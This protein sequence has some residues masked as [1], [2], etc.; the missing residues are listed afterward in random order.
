MFFKS[1]SGRFLL[2][3]IIFVML[4]EVLIFV[5]SVARFRF[6]YLTERLER[7]QIASLSLLAS[8]DEMISTE[9]E[10]EL[11]YNADVLN[12][13]LRRNSVRQ[14]V[15]S[16]PMPS[17]VDESF[18]LRNDSG[19]ELIRDAFE[20]LFIGGNRI[21]RVIGEP[22]KRG[23]ELIEITL[24]ETPMRRAM[25]EYGRNILVLSFVISLF[26]AMLL[27]G[28]VRRF[29]VR[30]IERLVRHIRY[31]QDA[32]EDARAIIQPTANVSELYDAETA[33]HGMETQL[34]QSLRQKE[35]L[36][37]LGG[38]VSKISHDL[39][40]IL[41]TTQLL[42]DRME[43]SNDPAVQRNAPKLVD[44]LSRAVNLCESTLTFGKAEEQAPE[45]SYFPLGLLLEDVVESELL[46]VEGGNIEITMDAPEGMRIE[47]DEEQI[48]RVVSNLVRNGR[49]VLSSREETGKIHVSGS[50]EDDAYTIT[51]RDNGP[52]VPE[53]A[54]EN[55][56]KPFEGS[57]RAGGSGLGLA[58][59]AELVKGHGG[60]LELVENSAD[61]ASFKVSLPKSN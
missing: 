47:A 53:R 2:L 61:G 27:F 7:S 16:S 49:Q 55:M 1:L 8:N 24:Q 59:S 39:R 6:D 28:A 14:L 31:F 11:L 20:S 58:I 44:S 25:I 41:T 51:V 42:A 4:A 29:M 52:G 5:P 23:G 18:D 22:V 17:A 15:L 46:A 35:R 56:F 3:T 37:A 33:L 10:A 34:N 36:A 19:P 13:T 54:I 38:A 57:V 21:L 45:I 60:T 9:L 48:F 32:P 50:E 26:T 43:A 30:P 12:I 40:N